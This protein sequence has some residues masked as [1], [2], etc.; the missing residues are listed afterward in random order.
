MVLNELATNAAKYGA[1]SSDAGIVT[2][3]WSTNE[4]G[5]ARTLRLLWE[6]RGGPA[7]TP[8]ERQGFGSRLIQANNSGRTT[9]EYLADGVRCQIEMKLT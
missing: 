1:L 7:V 3:T 2:A 5:K 9:L 6:E 8:P 4:Q